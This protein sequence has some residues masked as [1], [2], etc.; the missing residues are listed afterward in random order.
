VYTSSLFL[1]VLSY[2]VL[3]CRPSFQDDTTAVAKRLAS[4]H[5]VYFLAQDESPHNGPSCILTGG[6]GRACPFLEMVQTFVVLSEK[7]DSAQ[8]DTD[9]YSAKHVTGLSWRAWHWTPAWARWQCPW[10]AALTTNFIPFRTYSF[11]NSWA[12]LGAPGHSWAL[13]GR[14][15]CLPVC[16]RAF[17]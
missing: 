14:S 5:G 8:E 9:R 2:P 4:Q 17:H 1:S 7:V 3:T 6:I 12:L 15:S 11:R 16:D 13:L 10:H